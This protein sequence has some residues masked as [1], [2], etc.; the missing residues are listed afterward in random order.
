[1]AT[2]QLM[3]QD[4]YFMIKDFEN[5]GIN[6]FGDV[7]NLTTGKI[8]KPW[9]DGNGY[10]IVGLRENYKRVSKLI[11]RLLADLFIPNLEKKTNVDHIDRNRTNNKLLNLRWTTS[12]ENNQNKSKRSDNTTGVPGVRFDKMKWCARITLNGKQKHLGYFINIEDAITARKNAEQLY[13][14][15]FAPNINITINAI[16]FICK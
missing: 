15:D 2:L 3:M 4:K 6:I 1:M 7:K 8:L 14:G 9:L 13:F 16:F 10:Y 12:S 5:Y 11:H